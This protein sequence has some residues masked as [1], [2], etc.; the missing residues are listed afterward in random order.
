MKPKDK[1]T[2]YAGVDAATNW[3]DADFLNQSQEELENVVRASG[4]DFDG[5]NEKQVAQAITD[6]ALGAD[7]ALESGTANNYV[8]AISGS[9][10]LPNQLAVG[11][12]I[13]FRTGNANTNTTPTANYGGL[14]VKTIVAENG[15]DAIAVGDIK[16]GVVNTLE[17]DGTNWRLILSKVNTASET[18]AGAIKISTLAQVTEGNDDASAMTPLKFRTYLNGINLEVTTITSGSGVRTNGYTIWKSIATG[19]TVRKKVF[20]FV[21]SIGFDSGSNVTFPITFTNIYDVNVT[22]VN[23][24]SNIDNVDNPSHIRSLTLS[25]MRV[26]NGAVTVIDVI[27]SIEGI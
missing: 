27:Y 12:Q 23:N 1:R 5:D 15:T 19:L 14:G 3:V 26:C 6:H 10:Y 21:N 24:G 18:V 25:G 4:V 8:L 13:R 11:Y 9:R 20:G 22:T 16:V 7:Y 17:Y 2:D